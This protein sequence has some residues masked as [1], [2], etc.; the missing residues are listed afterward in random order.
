MDG[1]TT[2]TTASTITA[3]TITATTTDTIATTTTTLLPLLLH[4]STPLVRTTSC[5]VVWNYMH[6]RMKPNAPSADKQ[7]PTAELIVQHRPE[8]GSIYKQKKAGCIGVH[9]HTH[10]HNSTN[11]YVYTSMWL[12][13]TYTTRID[14]KVNVLH[15]T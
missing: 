1:T 2:T 15:S 4:V 9:K 13:H 8:Y 14:T 6:F 7:N 10:T 3:N 11:T 12:T 5:T